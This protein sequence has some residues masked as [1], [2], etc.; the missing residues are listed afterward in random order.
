MNL[1]DREITFYKNGA[2]QGTIDDLIASN[3]Q[4][5]LPAIWDGSGSLQATYNA[6]FGNPLITH[7]SSQS[8]E[9]GFGDFEYAPPSGYFALCSQNIAT[10][11]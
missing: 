8:D 10:K 7:S 1:D 4:F 9:A 3:D 2:D 6:N 11:G 5:Y